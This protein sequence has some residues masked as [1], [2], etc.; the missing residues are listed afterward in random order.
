MGSTPLSSFFG[1]IKKG[2]DVLSKVDIPAELLPY[3]A[4]LSSCHPAN[5][6]GD[7]GGSVN[8]V[9]SC[10]TIDLKAE[11]AQKDAEIADKDEEIIKKDAQIADKDA[12][13]A[14]LQ[15]MVGEKTTAARAVRTNSTLSIEV[16][17]QEVH[18]AILDAW[19]N[20]R[21]EAVEKR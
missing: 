9:D 10:K 21:E 14:R 2:L 17:K 18:D 19:A 20:Y 1:S 16:F 15:A 12:E 6:T 8:S 3:L 4:K 7:T 11:I 5:S 13:I